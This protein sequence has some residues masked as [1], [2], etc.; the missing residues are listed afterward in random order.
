MRREA[1]FSVMVRNV[2]LLENVVAA[3]ELHPCIVDYAVNV[4]LRKTSEQ[5]IAFLQ[6]DGSL[7]SDVKL[8]TGFD[9]AGVRVQ[10][11]G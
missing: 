7:L 6:R 1:D 5:W 3:M 9:D 11:D 2:G 10:F 8:S 4:G